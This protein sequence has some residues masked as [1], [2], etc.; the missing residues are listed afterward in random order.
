METKLSRSVYLDVAKGIG[1]I[2]VVWAHAKGPFS[3][4]MYQFHMPFFFIISG[5]LFNE[6]NSFKEFFIKKIKSLYIPFVS[7]NLL[8]L[9]IKTV[10]S[11]DH[12]NIEFFI[13]YIAK[14]LLLLDK[15]GQF[16]GATW[17]LGSL[18]MV[19]IIYKILYMSIENSPYKI[20]LIT[21]FFITFAVIGF[22]IQLPYMQS[23]SIILSMF[24]AM[25]YLIKRVIADAKLKLN[26]IPAIIFGVLYIIIG[27][28]NQANMGRNQYRSEVLF[29][30]G[31]VYATYCVIYLSKTIEKNNNKI[32]IKIKDVLCLLGKK[33]ID[34]VIW[35]FVL[36]KV[37]VAV[38]L[39]IDHI[40]IHS[41]RQFL[42]YYPTYYTNNGWWIVYTFVGLFGSILWCMILRYGFWGKILKRVHMV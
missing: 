1:I 38:Q 5:Y 21:I 26:K 27:S 40:K 10:S 13:K 9:L 23:R 15:D 2:L 7:W 14:I 12:F 16:F 31:V 25:G 19:S 20:W 36:F 22:E 42:H 39:Y 4:Y 30:I 28:Y 11:I 29:V 33:S 24:F 8:S 18:F 34:I 6:K 35:Q 32:I 41:V 37:V 17:F 3:N